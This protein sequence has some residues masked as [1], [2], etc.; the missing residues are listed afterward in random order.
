MLQCLLRAKHV[1]DVARLAYGYRQH[2]D[3]TVWRKPTLERFLS[4]RDYACQWLSLSRKLD[5]DGP[6]VTRRM[7]REARREI[8]RDAL[9]SLAIELFKVVPNPWSEWL[10]GLDRLAE[11]AN[12]LP[13]VARIQL[14]VC[15][16]WR[17]W[18]VTRLVVEFPHRMREKVRRA[19][20]T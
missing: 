17:W 18:W 9:G 12:L 8:A 15:R 3:S 11:Q 19:L 6:F 10:E 7:M 16:R 20:F 1:I 13:A 4:R 2:A 14:F 5:V